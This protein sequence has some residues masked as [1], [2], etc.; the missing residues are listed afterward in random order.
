MYLF[1]RSSSN[2]GLYSTH[3]LEIIDGYGI[4]RILKYFDAELWAE[5]D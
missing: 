3:L 1:D 5:A 2:F 4:R